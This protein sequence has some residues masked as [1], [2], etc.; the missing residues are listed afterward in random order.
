MKLAD[1]N[2]II[3]Q[4]MNEELT[5]SINRNHPI[6]QNYFSYIKNVI[7]DED[8]LSKVEPD[9]LI[10]SC[11]NFLVENKI[12]INGSIR[13]KANERWLSDGTVF[14]KNVIRFI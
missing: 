12:R 1:I 9:A 2:R 8:Y 7:D 5:R 14:S 13:I 10:I 11:E 6:V 3:L 4:V